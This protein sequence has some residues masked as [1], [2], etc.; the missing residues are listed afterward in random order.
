[1]Q[2]PIPDTVDITSL[3]EVARECEAPVL[4]FAGR[5]VIAAVHD[6]W[7]RGESA[8]PWVR[9]WGNP[10]FE[11]IVLTDA[12]EGDLQVIAELVEVLQRE[13]SFGGD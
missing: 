12:D 5:E 13:A 3:G 8:L 10:D 7:A 1:M 2:I 9:P 11:P 4:W 6:A